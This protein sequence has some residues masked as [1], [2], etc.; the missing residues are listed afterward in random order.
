MAPVILRSTSL[1]SSIPSSRSTSS[2]CF[3]EL[4]SACQ[5]CRIV[6]ELYRTGDE[7][8]QVRVCINDIGDATVGC[9][10]FVA[11]Y[12]PGVL[13]TSPLSGAETQHGFGLGEAQLA[14]GVVD[15]AVR[16]VGVLGR[17]SN[18]GSSANS[19][20]PI[21]SADLG[22]VPRWLQHRQLYENLPSAVWCVP[23]SGL[24]EAWL[25]RSIFGSG[26]PISIAVLMLN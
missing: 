19:S 26:P 16:D 23:I 5:R 13:D 10:R 1:S 6:V 9:Q 24:P 4:R 14:D 17:D 25:L 3:G 22:P 20:S 12:L 21:R 8:L 11:R 7:S 15:D 2:G 18:R